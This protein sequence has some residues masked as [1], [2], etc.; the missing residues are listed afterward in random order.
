MITIKIGDIQPVACPKCKAKHGYRTS[1]YMKTHYYDF[2][3]E[4]GEK[5]G[6]DYSEWQPIIHKSK[7]VTCHNCCCKLPFQVERS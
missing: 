5:I 2:Y 1:D 3:S 4:E 7:S 6:G